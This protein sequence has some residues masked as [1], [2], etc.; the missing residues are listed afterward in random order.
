MEGEHLLYLDQSLKGVSPL[1][2]LVFSLLKSYHDKVVV[3]KTEVT[4]LTDFPFCQCRQIRLLLY[5]NVFLE[6][7]FH[8]VV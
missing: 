8:R 1:N 7:G 2:F 5:F 3:P 6:C 4:G